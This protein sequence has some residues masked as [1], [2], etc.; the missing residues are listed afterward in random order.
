MLFFLI[1][2][3]TTRIVYVSNGLSFAREQLSKPLAQL[4]TPVGNCVEKWQ[5]R[6]ICHFDLQS[7]ESLPNCVINVLILSTERNK[8]NLLAGKTSELLKSSYLTQT[9]LYTAEE[10]RCVFDDI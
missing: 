9:R 4:H 1:D 7:S 6:H 10:I 5:N 2:C 3:I 8:R